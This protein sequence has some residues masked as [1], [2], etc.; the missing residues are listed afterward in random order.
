MN[1]IT[2]IIV[3]V[4]VI[5]FI[6][7]LLNNFGIIDIESLFSINNSNVGPGLQDYGPN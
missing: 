4:V 1:K 2:M 6:L 5:F 7:L 3:F